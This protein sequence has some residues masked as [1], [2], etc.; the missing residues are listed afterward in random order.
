MNP[1]RTPPCLFFL[2]APR[3]RSR[4]RRIVWPMNADRPRTPAGER[5]ERVRARRGPIG[6]DGRTR[7]PS[8]SVHEAL[9]LVELVRRTP[10]TKTLFVRGH[11]TKRAAVLGA[12]G[13]NAN[14]A[15]VLA[16]DGPSRRASRAPRRAAAALPFLSSKTLVFMAGAGTSRGADDLGVVVHVRGESRRRSG[17]RAPR[18]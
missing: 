16:G 10:W 4:R 18:T 6:A 5:P 3:R 7:G 14:R 2:R 17:P 8:S 11:A 1:H 12:G 15:R 9:D 13:R